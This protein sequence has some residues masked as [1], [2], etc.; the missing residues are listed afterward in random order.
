MKATI[1]RAAL[2]ALLATGTFVLVYAQV[3]EAKAARRG[4]AS[5]GRN[6]GEGFHHR[7]GAR[8]GLRPAPHLNQQVRNDQPPGGQ[9]ASTSRPLYAPVECDT[10]LSYMDHA[11]AETFASRDT[12]LIVIARL[13]AGERAARLNRQRLAGIEGYVR[14][15]FP[16]LK[17]VMAEGSKTNGL[18]RVEFYVGGRLLYSMPIKK[19]AKSY[20]DDPIRV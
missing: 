1:Y 14:S 11:M 19:N 3:S 20:C 18:G 10:A 4:Q 7:A 15:K 5:A 17:Y 2:G 16:D 13:G 8:T 9:G 12:Y 6:E